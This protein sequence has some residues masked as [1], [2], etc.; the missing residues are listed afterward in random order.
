[1]ND[2]DDY[3]AGGEPWVVGFLREW[4]LE[5]TQGNG[6]VRQGWSAW[7]RKPDNDQSGWDWPFKRI[8]AHRENEADETEYLVKWVGHRY[9]P[10]Y[11]QKDNLDDVSGEIYDRANDVVHGG[12]EDDPMRKKRRT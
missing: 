3:P 10:F 2:P 1:M 9:M 4:A 5:Y 6:E 7:D 11:V 8:T 12:D